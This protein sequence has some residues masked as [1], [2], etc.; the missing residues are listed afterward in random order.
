MAA[1]FAAAAGAAAGTAA[2]ARAAERSAEDAHAPYEAVIFDLDGTL[3]DTES[4]SGKRLC[5]KPVTCAHY[6]HVDLDVL[7]KSHACVHICTIIH[8]YIQT[9]KLT[10]IYT[11]VHTNRQT[12]IQAFKQLANRYIHTYIPK[13]YIHKYVQKI[14]Y[15][16]THTFAVRA[17]NH[18]RAQHTVGGSRRS[19]VRN[20]LA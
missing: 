8:T 3:L 10:M 15:M 17:H 6:V 7:Q 2:A 1:A 13:A 14:S 19:F 11:C 18:M 9:Y 5:C 4:L 20:E 16:D 12:K